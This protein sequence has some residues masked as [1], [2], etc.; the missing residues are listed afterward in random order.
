FVNSLSLINKFC[1]LRPE[2]V[3][4]GYHLTAGV[5]ELCSGVCTVITSPARLNCS[6]ASLA[7]L[8]SGNEF[9]SFAGGADSATA[10]Q[11]ERVGT[12]SHCRSR[13]PAPESSCSA[14]SERA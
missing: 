14:C 5:N 6:I 8:S 1:P 7:A 10:S 9:M 11:A 13:T 2:R 4:G 12:S 3:N